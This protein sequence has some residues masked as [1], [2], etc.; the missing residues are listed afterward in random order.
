MWYV[1]TVFNLII[2]AGCSLDGPTKPNKPYNGSHS[3]TFNELLINN[4]LLAKE[5]GKIPEIQ[6]G[7]SDDDVMVLEEIVKLYRNNHKAFDKAFEQMYQ[8]GK[9]EVRK[10]C[11]PLQA[12]YWL[13]E[14]GKIDNINIHNYDL[15]NLLNNAWWST[16]FDYNDTKGR[17]KNFRDVAERLNSPVLLDYYERRDFRY[18]SFEATGYK[19]DYGGPPPRVIFRQKTGSCSFFTSFSAYCLSKAGYQ[20]KA[21]TI[22]WN[23]GVGGL[24]RVCEFVDKDGKFY[25]MDNSRKI[26]IVGSGIT[27]KDTYLKGVT[28][29]SYGYHRFKH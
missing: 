3:P 7:I 2:F 22:K 6:D 13:I 1:I 8:V 28:F 27:T 24:H 4:P 23:D 29:V 14:D 17:W 18:V 11:S 25:I 15:I 5:L 9:P 16:G 26:L 10:Y 20:A 12:V 21:I 19:L